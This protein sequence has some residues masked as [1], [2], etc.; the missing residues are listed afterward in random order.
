MDDYIKTNV[1]DIWFIELLNELADY[2]TRNT[3]RAIAFGLCL[4]H[5][6]DIFQMQV[7]EREEQKEKLGF[8]YYKKEGNRLIP[9]KE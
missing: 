5:N 9:Y 3:D 8:I 7:R 2:G 6:I 1:D 4:V